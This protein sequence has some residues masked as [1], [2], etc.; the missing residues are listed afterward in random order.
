MKPLSP[1]LLARALLPV[2]SVTLIACWAPEGRERPQ[3]QRSSSGMMAG[4]MPMMG[5][6]QGMMR[7]GMMKGMMGGGM[8]DMRSIHGL[9]ASHE[10]IERQVEDLPNGV[11]TRTTS[12][13]PRVAELIRTHV[14]QMKERYERDQPI[15]PMDPLF[16]ELFEHRREASMQVRDIPGGVEVLHT[17]SNPQVVLLIRQHARHFVNAV[18]DKGM[19]G[20]MGPTPLPEGYTGRR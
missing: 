14:R 11:R 6:H 2:L 1:H 5:M 17:S 8:E 15:R 12:S 18:V 13:D 19:A 20:A 9:V 4:G 16:R 3:A 10:S 7:N